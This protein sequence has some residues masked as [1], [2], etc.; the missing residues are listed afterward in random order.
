PS[1][2][3][4]SASTDT[5]PGATPLPLPSLTPAEQRVFWEVIMGLSNQQIGERLLLTPR[6]VQGHVSSILHKLRLKNRFQLMHYAYSQ[7]FILP[8]K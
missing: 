5:A 7:G 1:T 2:D 4:L 3:S 8:K 6:T